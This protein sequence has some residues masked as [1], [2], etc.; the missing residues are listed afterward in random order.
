[1]GAKDAVP[2]GTL[3][4]ASGIAPVKTTLLRSRWG[5]TLIASVAAHSVHRFADIR[6]A[7]VGTEYRKINEDGTTVAIRTGLDGTRL[8]G[9]R[10]PPTVEKPDYFFVAGGASLFKVAPNGVA[11]LWGI[12]PPADGFAAAIVAQVSKVIDALDS[13]A[14]WSPSNAV[15]ADEATIKQEGA[16]SM[17]MTVTAFNTGHATKTFTP[18]LDL[19][20][21]TDGTES[22]DEDFIVIAVRVENPEAVDFLQLQFDVDAGNFATDYYTRTIYGEEGVALSEDTARQTEGV[23]SISRF[24]S[25]DEIARNL[26]TVVLHDNVTIQE[27]LGK[28]GFSLGSAVWVKLRIPKSTFK[29]SGTGPGTWAT[30]SAVRLIVKTT[31]R[32][33]AV[34]YWDDLKL[35]GSTGM[36]GTY[37]YH[38]IFRNSVSG[39]RSNPNPTAVRV[40]NVE[41]Q[42]VSL[43]SLP[44]STDPQVDQ[45]EIYRTVGNGTLFFRVGVIEDNSTTTFLDNAADFAGLNSAE[46]ANIMSSIQLAFDNERPD[47]SWDDTEGPHAGRLW[48]ARNPREGWRGRVAYSPAGR[49]EGVENFIDITGD[50][51]P[52]QKLVMWN[53]AMFVFTESG[54]FQIVG[55]GPFVGRRVFGAPGTLW[56]LSVK[57]TPYGIA[58]LAHDGVR[59][60]NGAQSKLVMPEAVQLIFKG[61]IL[62]DVTFA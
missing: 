24:I 51:D 6:F 16:A 39:T 35:G 1:M 18:D 4:R 44:I 42:A 40:S 43:T 45:R 38:V 58:Y 34:V 23:G 33:D 59:L 3:R 19:T 5:S 11:T 41:R 28:T 13:A 22:P 47:D 36:Q 17:K 46:N 2:E 49:S 54:L 29:R 57:A 14:S 32:G 15:L 50:D 27:A 53:S 26:G 8:T 25:D 37:K 10:I 12:V 21:Y 52:T 9:A 30:V 20:E 61:E 56:P 55:T 62:E 7:G 60:F 31:G 48:L